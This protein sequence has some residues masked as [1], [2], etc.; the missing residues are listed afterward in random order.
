[1]VIK[2]F[3]KFI[4]EADDIDPKNVKKA[5][6]LLQDYV[7]GNVP[8]NYENE[9]PSVDQLF[10]QLYQLFDEKM[11]QLMIIKD[12]KK[13]EGKGIVVDTKDN[14]HFDI[15][16][17]APNVIIPYDFHVEIRK[18]ENGDYFFSSLKLEPK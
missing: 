14:F 18:N 11:L 8:D 7:N 3:L 10:K 2:S 1:M 4:V 15:G 9:Q 16:L 13:F 12:G 6:G 17:G 5:N